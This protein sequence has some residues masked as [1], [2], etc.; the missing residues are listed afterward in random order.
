MSQYIR[1]LIKTNILSKFQKDWMKTVATREPDTKSVTDRQTDR[2]TD[3]QTDGQTDDGK[4]IPMCH[5]CFAAG[6]TKTITQHFNKKSVNESEILRNW[7][8]W[9]LARHA[10]ATNE[11]NAV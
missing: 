11:N 1:D 6:D 8:T 4:V 3:R 10:R 9:Y 2:R 7:L 5:L